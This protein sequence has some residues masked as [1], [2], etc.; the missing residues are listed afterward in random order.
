MSAYYLDTSALVKR[1]V[2]EQ[3]STWTRAICDPTGN[4]VLVTSLLL[5]AELTSALNRRVREGTILTHDYEGLRDA[6]RR[7]CIHDYQILPISNAVVGLACELLE[8]HRLRA[9]DALHL[10]TAL[11]VH[12]LFTDLGLPGPVFVGADARLLDA[13]QTEGLDTKNPDQYP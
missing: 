9:S 4:A 12:R 7:D 3:G 1:Y 6:F 13:A 10:A 5:V 8:R 11:T 2:D